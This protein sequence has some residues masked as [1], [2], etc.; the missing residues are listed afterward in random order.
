MLYLTN[1]GIGGHVQVAIYADSGNAPGVLLA[2]SSSEIVS[3]N[4]WHDFSGFNVNIVGGSPYWL[5]CEADSAALLWYYNNGG[6]NYYQGGVGFGFGI[7]PN[8]YVRGYFGSYSP[9]IYAIYS[10]NK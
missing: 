3:S 4:G 5:A 6:A 2:K 8:P 9:S 1:S 10:T 7:F